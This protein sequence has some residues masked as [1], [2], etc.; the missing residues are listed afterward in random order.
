MNSTKNNAKTPIIEAQLSFK[1]DSD[2]L[3]CTHLKKTKWV[4]K[5]SNSNHL[6][7]FN[8]DESVSNS[9]ANLK[10]S[11][12]D[13]KL[14]EAAISEEEKKQKHQDVSIGIKSENQCDHCK[15]LFVSKY[16]LKKHI[17]DVH[18]GKIR[19]YQKHIKKDNKYNCKICGKQYTHTKNLKV[20][21][22]MNHS[23]QE[24]L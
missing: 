17:L 18:S 3:I 11:Q 7:N 23:K 8:S 20:H 19:K 21:Y 5:V 16:T 9:S 24:L 10:D 1:Q 2:Y 6:K 13:E 22:A 14:L 12:I 15:K 4:V